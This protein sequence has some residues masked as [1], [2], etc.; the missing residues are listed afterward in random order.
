MTTVKNGMPLQMYSFLAY[1]PEENTL[2]I[3]AG[4]KLCKTPRE[5]E[6]KKEIIR[7]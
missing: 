6:E 2:R 4:N 5:K 3:R 1:S 7:L